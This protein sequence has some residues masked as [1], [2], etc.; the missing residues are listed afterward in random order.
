MTSLITSPPY[1]VGVFPLRVRLAY[2]RRGG[3]MFLA[4]AGW[5][6]TVLVIVVALIVFGFIGAWRPGARP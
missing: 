5:L 3:T 1:G 2:R 4:V 6:W